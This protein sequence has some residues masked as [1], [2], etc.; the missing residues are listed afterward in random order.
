MRRKRFS[1]RRPIADAR[2]TVRTQKSF[3]AVRTNTTTYAGKCRSELCRNCVT[4]PRNYPQTSTFTGSHQEAFCGGKSL[5]RLREEAFRCHSVSV[6]G[7]VFQ[8]CSFNHS[9]ISPSLESTTCERSVRDYRTRRSVP[10]PFLHGVSF[11]RFTGH[12]RAHRPGAVSDHSAV[13]KSG[14]PD[15]PAHPTR[16]DTPRGVSMRRQSRESA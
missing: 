14:N 9:D 13:P 6:A 2:G 11:Q 5:N 8:A 1:G 4:S 3:R 15:H 16:S 12:E 10:L 7:V